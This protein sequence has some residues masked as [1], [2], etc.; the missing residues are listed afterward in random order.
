[1]KHDLTFFSL[2]LSEKEKSVFRKGMFYGANSGIWAYRNI[3][4]PKPEEKLKISKLERFTPCS[5]G[6]FLTWRVCKNS[7]IY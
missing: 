1:M 6:L 3:V 4:Q 2:F 7:P 5:K